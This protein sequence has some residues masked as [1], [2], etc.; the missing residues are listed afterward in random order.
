MK[1][2]TLSVV[3]DNISGP[4]NRTGIADSPLLRILLAVCQKSREP[5][6][7]DMMDSFVLFAYASLAVSFCNDY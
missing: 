2:S 1:D 4:L 7:W 3:E 6:F 5:S